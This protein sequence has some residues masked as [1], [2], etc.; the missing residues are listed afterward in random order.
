[1]F[2]SFALATFVYGDA[3]KSKRRASGIL[4]AAF[5][6]RDRNRTG[7][8]VSPKRRIL[9]R[10]KINHNCLISMPCVTRNDFK[11]TTQSATILDSIFAI[12]T[13]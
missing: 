7:T 11:A 13:F 5:G 4:A 10:I 9:S 8:L 3:L 1:M 6:A 2:L 12:V